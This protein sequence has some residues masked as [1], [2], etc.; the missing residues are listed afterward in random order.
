MRRHWDFGRL[1]A[2]VN[3]P[4]FSGP[5]RVLLKGWAGYPI[6]RSEPHSDNFHPSTKGWGME[7]SD[8]TFGPAPEA[9]D[10][11]ILVLFSLSFC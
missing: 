1:L 7:C 8:S 2:K 5:F 11:E 10:P 9:F 3:V 4:S 6:N